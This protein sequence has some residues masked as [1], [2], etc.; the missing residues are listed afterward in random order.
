MIL[1]IIRPVLGGKTYRIDDI[2]DI[3]NIVEKINRYDGIH[4][5]EDVIDWLD[6]QTTRWAVRDD[7]YNKIEDVAE[8]FLKLYDNDWS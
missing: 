4:S 3:W 7:D 2:S 6:S 1:E 5:P 8:R